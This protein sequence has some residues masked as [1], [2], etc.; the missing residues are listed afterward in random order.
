MRLSC[1]GGYQY[2]FDKRL[3]PVWTLYACL[4]VYVVHYNYMEGVRYVDGSFQTCFEESYCFALI[5]LLNRNVGP[6]SN[7]VCSM[8]Y[9]R[10]YKIAGL[11]GAERTLRFLNDTRDAPPADHRGLS[12]VV[13]YAAPASLAA[14]ASLSQFY[15]QMVPPAVV[16]AYWFNGM[17]QMVVYVLVLVQ[18]YVLARG[19][20]RVND[21]VE[22]LEVARDPSS[23]GLS[24]TWLTGVYD[25]LCTL[26]GYVNRAYTPEMLLQW[27]Y[28]I[29]RVIMV[30]FR[31]LE[32]ADSPMASVTSYLVLQHL[33][34]LLIFVVHTSCMCTIGQRLSSEVLLYD[35]IVSQGRNW[36]GGSK[37][38]TPPPP[39][40][41]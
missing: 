38:P 29:I 33:G 10:W 4:N 12:R 8:F 15:M 6:S 7:V 2:S 40:N 16:I 39:R 35:I 32:I 26:A 31:L 11:A 13:W 1:A 14:Y 25:E 3:I 5:E 28:N 36:G 9:G 37:S 17:G 22:A 34:E 30:M 41:F 23:A 21:M 18:Y 27:A 20:S 24:L 19:F